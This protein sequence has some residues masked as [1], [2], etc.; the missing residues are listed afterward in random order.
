M[1][2]DTIDGEAI[3]EYIQRALNLTEDGGYCKLSFNGIDLVAD[4][5]SLV[6]DILKIYF[7]KCEIRRLKGD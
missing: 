1:K 7:L 5:L 4:K 6:D 3:D 2:V